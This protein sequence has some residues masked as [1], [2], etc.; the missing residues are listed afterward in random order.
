MEFP[1]KA[2]EMSLEGLAVIKN[3]L[4]FRAHLVPVFSFGENEV[5]DQVENCRGSWLRWAQD[6]LQRLMGISLPLFH[7]R[8]IFQYSFGLMPYRRPIHTVGEKAALF[9]HHYVQSLIPSIPA[10][11]GV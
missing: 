8:G 7:A 1:G 9:S 11:R 2:H 4:C 10:G 5:Y 6:R 3:V